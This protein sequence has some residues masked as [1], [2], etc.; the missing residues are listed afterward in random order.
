MLVG[1]AYVDGVVDGEVVASAGEYEGSC[2]RC[3]DPV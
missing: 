1:E 3:T 2:L